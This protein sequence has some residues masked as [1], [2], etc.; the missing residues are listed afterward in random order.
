MEDVELEGHINLFLKG[1]CLGNQLQGNTCEKGEKN[2]QTL[3]GVQMGNGGRNKVMVSELF[4]AS[5]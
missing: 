1:S 2:K 3:T 5:V 4:G